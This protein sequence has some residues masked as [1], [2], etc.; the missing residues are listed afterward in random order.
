VAAGEQGDEDPLEHPV[1][2]HDHALDL[3][4]G[5][6]EGLSGVVGMAGG[7]EGRM[8]VGHVCLSVARRGDV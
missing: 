2:P 8:L 5:R 6:L 4:Q 3:E 7:A 1:L